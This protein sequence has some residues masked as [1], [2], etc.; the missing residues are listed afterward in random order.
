MAECRGRIYV[1]DDDPVILDS[2]TQLL[3]AERYQVDHGASF[4]VAVQALA[5][6]Q[7][8]LVISDINM[9][10]ADGFE[11]LRVLK[12]RYPS[13]M[14][15]MI[16]GYGTIESAVEAIRMG[17]YDYL[18]K[19]IVDDQLR[20]VVQRAMEQCSLVRGCR[21]DRLSS[22]SSDRL[23]SRSHSRLE[24][25]FGL[26]NV[27]GHDYKMLRVFDLVEAVSDSA[28]NVLI[29]GESG[30]GKSQIARVI[31]HRSRRRDGPFVEVS[32]GAIPEALLESEL[33]GHVRGSFTGAV[34]DKPGKFKVADGGTLFLDEI[35]AASPALQ[36]KLLRVLQEREFEPIGSNK[37]EKVDVRMIMATN[38]ELENEVAAGRFRQDLFYRINVVNIVLPTLSER[39]GDIPLLAEK[40]LRR[41]CERANKQVLGLTGEAMKYLQRHRWPGNVREL[42]NVVERAVVLVKGRHIDVDDLPPKL[43]EACEVSPKTM[44]SPPTSLKAALEEPERRVIEAA[45]RCNDWC[46]QATAA[47]LEINRNTLYKKMKRYRLV[48]DPAARTVRT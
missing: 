3:R 43:V 6:Q 5:G 9:P 12:A 11:L 30:T 20:L 36:I 17:A 15:I 7:Y 46:R 48:A 25:R 27:I 13:V 22:L 24:E 8:D 37:T 34:S 39:I 40:F 45:L 28:V 31:H 21:W 18:T 4:N 1:V 32:C 26:D 29:E 44:H 41:C 42:E 14:V 2:M 19:P 35:A 10:D 16:T 38:V 33:F 47:Q 23:E